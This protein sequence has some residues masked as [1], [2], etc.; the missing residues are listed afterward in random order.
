[1]TVQI[2]V[3]KTD[4]TVVT[5]LSYRLDPT[6]SVQSLLNVNPLTSYHMETASGWVDIPVSDIANMTILPLRS[7]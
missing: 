1:M 3:F 6:S 7:T 2:Q 5:G 4:G